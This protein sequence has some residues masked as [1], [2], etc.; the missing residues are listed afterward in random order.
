MR[1]R[2]FQRPLVGERRYQKNQLIKGGVCTVTKVLPGRDGP[3]VYYTIRRNGEKTDDV[4]FGNGDGTV[5]AEGW[6]LWSEWFRMKLTK[7]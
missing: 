5:V 7:R 1:R 2:T 4:C 6:M 3:R